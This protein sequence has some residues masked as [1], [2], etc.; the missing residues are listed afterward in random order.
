M[1]ILRAQGKASFQ[2]ILRSIAK[3]AGSTLRSTKLE[4]DNSLT[5]LNVEHHSKSQASPNLW[6]KL[7]HLRQPNCHN[8]ARLGM[9]KQ[10]PLVRPAR[11]RKFLPRLP[12]SL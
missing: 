10:F 8:G 1:R 7:P 6:S 9:L 4:Q 2:W 3:G 11:S 5:A 12:S